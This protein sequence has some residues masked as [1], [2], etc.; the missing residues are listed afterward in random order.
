MTAIGID[1][2]TTNSVIAY[3][4]AGEVRLFIPNHSGGR[5]TIRSA[6]ATGQNGQPTIGKAAFLKRGLSGVSLMDRFKLAIG[7]ERASDL[8]AKSFLSTLIETFRAE[9]GAGDVSSVV[10]TVPDLWL[11]DE[12]QAAYRRLLDI[13]GD[14]KLPVRKLL[15]EPVAAASYFAHVQNQRGV[16]FEGHALV[17]DHGGGTLDISLVN[18]SGTDVTTIDGLGIGTQDDGIGGMHFDQCMAQHFGVQDDLENWLDQF[19]TYKVELSSDI[20]DG[21]SAYLASGQS[22]DFNTTVFSVLG[23]DVKASDLYHVFEDHFEPR[24]RD[25]LRTVTTRNAKRLNASPF[26]VVAVG[27]FSG[28]FPV[29][30]LLE[31]EF[32]RTANPAM[33]DSGIPVSESSFAIAKGACLLSAN[34]TNV[35]ETCPVGVAVQVKD[36]RGNPKRLPLLRRGA[37]LHTVSKPVFAE[38]DILARYHGDL[39]TLPIYFQIEGSSGTDTLASDLPAAQI[40][41]AF[42]KTEAWR[43]GAYVTDDLV[44]NVVFQAVGRHG[45]HN[46]IALGELME[47]AQRVQ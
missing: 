17:Y 42:I 1:F 10:L 22:D 31:K 29:Q 37:P 36:E 9:G 30:H 44:V 39:K 34:L 19:E 46:Q 14:L 4:A 18:V 11:R 43:I 12:G 15:S 38:A 6:I 45:G 27:G 21:M 20:E 8:A 16:E 28:F 7:R 47:M 24:I 23:V 35:F 41:P 25:C 13:C 32:D 40:L 33:F 2:G 26:K 3:F 5:P